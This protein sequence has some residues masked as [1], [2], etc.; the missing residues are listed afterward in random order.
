MIRRRRGHLRLVGP[1]EPPQS[2]LPTIEIASAHG[3]TWHVSHTRQ[4]IELNHESRSGDSWGHFG[5]HP[6]LIAAL[7]EAHRI[8]PLAAPWGSP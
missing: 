3:G 2:F 8:D 4:G 5:F 7:N 1:E 6:C